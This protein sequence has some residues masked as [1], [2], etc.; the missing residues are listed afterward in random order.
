MKCFPALTAPNPALIFGV[1]LTL[2]FGA[3]GWWLFSWL[4]MPLAWMI[5]A[6]IFC[7]TAAVM[8]APGKNA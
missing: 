4:K 6:M 8:G 1:V 2:L 5:G 7:T 3:A